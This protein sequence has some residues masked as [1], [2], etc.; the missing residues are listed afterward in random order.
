MDKL[1]RDFS[2]LRTEFVSYVQS[3]MHSDDR[4]NVI[5]KLTGVDDNT[6]S[7]TS[8]LR[9]LNTEKC[10]IVIQDGEIVGYWQTGA[11]LDGLLDIADH[12]A[13][14]IEAADAPSAAGASGGS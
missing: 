4:R 1:R 11:W 10:R 14:L 8:Y 7:A 12:C 5:H 6:V 9:T 13:N 2:G 3:E